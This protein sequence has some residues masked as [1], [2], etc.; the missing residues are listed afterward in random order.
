MKEITIAEFEKLPKKG[1]IA[2]KLLEVDKLYYI[3]DIRNKTNPVFIGRY[4]KLVT[5]YND[6]SVSYNYRFEDVEYLVNPSKYNQQ[7][8]NTYGNIEKYYEVLYPTPTKLDIQNKKATISELRDFISEK[9]A[10]PHD[11]TPTISFMGKDY[12]KVRDKFNN[13]SNRSN[14]RSSLSSSRSS[15]KRLSRSSS[16]PSSSKTRSSR[17][18]SKRS[19]SN[20]SYYRSSSS[21]YRSY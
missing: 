1:P 16:K 15:R 11:E 14:H 18:S 13:R 12:R 4:V 5:Y 19:S 21:S 10:E 9:K 3:R 8:R 20:R 2:G 6:N 7:P 17:K